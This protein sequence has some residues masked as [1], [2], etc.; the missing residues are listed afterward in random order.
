[1][2]I[3]D[4]INIAFRSI[5]ANRLRSI[6]TAL[7][8]IIGVA[9]VIALIAIGQGTQQGVKQEIM[10]LGSNLMFV[11][12]GSSTD[13][14]SGAKGGRGSAATLVLSDVTAIMDAEI[15]GV[16]GA[17]GQFNFPAQAI[18]GGNN[19]RVEVV[20]VD[21]EYAYVRD[22]NIEY[23]SFISENDISRKAMNIVLGYAVAES[24]FPTGDPI[25]ANVRVNLGGRFG[26]NFRVIGVLAESGGQSAQDASVYIPIPSLMNRLRFLKNSSGDT[27]IQQISIKID[28]N[29]DEEVIKTELETVLL[30]QHDVVEPDFI[31]NSQNDLVN[32]ASAVSQTLSILLGSIA[33][34]SLVVGGIG[35]MNIM[36]VSVTE[37]TREIGIRRAVGALSKDIRLQFIS[38]ALVVT[39]GSGII[40]VIVGITVALFVNGR[41]IAGQPMVTVIELWSVI[42][43]FGV[44]T[45]V[46]LISGS[47]PAHRASMLDPIVALR[48]D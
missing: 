32:A 10:G 38:E 5:Y 30:T 28:E 34:I 40:G 21:T 17:S 42:V 29:L 3:I 43:A 18:G 44:A 16:Y 47:Y 27:T 7:G 9:S 33:G 39:I 8:M 36:L 25:G 35:V 26:F 15:E 48:T 14:S 19:E 13:Q 24:L 11:Q 12:P 46:G 37:R 4:A 1:M 22:L 20:A 41:E 2:T 23:G 45:M 31:I 6:L